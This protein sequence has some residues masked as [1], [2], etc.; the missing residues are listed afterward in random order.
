M[1]TN[2]SR[3]THSGECTKTF[4]A[5]AADTDLLTERPTYARDRV[6]RKP[7]QLIV[8]GA[9]DLA[10]QYFAGVTATSATAIT[11]VW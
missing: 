2:A 4:A 1:T 8:G 7:R 10:L 5:I 3:Q 9:G 6:A 11:V